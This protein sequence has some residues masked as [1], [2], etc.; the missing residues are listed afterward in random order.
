MNAAIKLKMPTFA[1]EA[2]FLFLSANKPANLLPLVL[3]SHNKGLLTLLV[4]I[5]DIITDVISHEH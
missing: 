1:P 2:D 5:T 3:T 4:T